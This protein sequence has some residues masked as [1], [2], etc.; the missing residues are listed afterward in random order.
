[1]LDHLNE[2]M[3]E[4]VAQQE[5]FFLATADA[6]GECDNTFRAGPPGF[7]RVL[8]THTLAFPEY[9]GNGVHASLGNIQENPH[10]GILLVDFLNARI[11]L[12]VNG[13]ARLVEDAA[14]RADHPDLPVDPVPGRRAELWVEVTVEE[15]YIHC[16]KHIPQ[17]QKAPRR[18]ARAWGTDDVRRKGGDYFGVAAGAATRAAKADAASA[19]KSG[20]AEAAPAAAPAKSG[21]PTDASPTPAP[22]PHAGTNPQP[23]G[24]RNPGEAA[25]PGR[26]PAPTPASASAPGSAKSGG[27]GR[28]SASV[29]AWQ[30]EA[31]RVLAEAE[32][33]GRTAARASEA[34]ASHRH[35]DRAGRADRAFQGW[36]TG[37]A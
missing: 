37:T 1:M 23:G 4:F 7:L 25:R 12:H 17:F 2:R 15:A 3:C 16:S 36:F 33:R 22:A 10:L 29:L 27:S 6:R 30:R 26:E 11:G 19:A 32:A 8:D 13:T 35:A 14:M 18:P 20:A 24:A 9:R 34:A 5:M 28:L 31:R 21:T